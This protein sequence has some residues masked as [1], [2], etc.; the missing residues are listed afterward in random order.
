M[1]ATDSSEP[2]ESISSA[3][4]AQLLH[5]ML[6]DG[7]VSSDRRLM[8]YQGYK[9]WTFSPGSIVSANQLSLGRVE[10][11]A[12]VLYEDDVITNLT[13]VITIAHASAV[14]TKLAVYSITGELLAQTADV[15]AAWATS[16]QK[17]NPL[18]EPFVVPETGVYMLSFL[19]VGG[20]PPTVYRGAGWPATLPVGSGKGLTRISAAT[21]LTDLPASVTWQDS[22]YWFFVGAS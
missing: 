10:G 21:G 5:E 22:T 4:A 16:G 1:P 17:I 7:P 11:M 8:D 14:L 3:R 13:A 6:Q 2:F 15:K 12:A 19:V 9:G 18:V 20:T